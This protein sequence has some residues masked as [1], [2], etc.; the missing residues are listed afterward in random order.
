MYAVLLLV[1][2]SLLLTSGYAWYMKSWLW[3]LHGGSLSLAL[4]PSA[5]WMSGWSLV[6]TV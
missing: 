4:A 2:L 6:A 1:A 3:L 5:L